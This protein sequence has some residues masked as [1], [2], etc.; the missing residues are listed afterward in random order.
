MQQVINLAGCGEVVV[1]DDRAKRAEDGLKGFEEQDGLGGRQEAA[2]P[3]HANPR[4][5]TQCLEVVCRVILAAPRVNGSV[6]QLVHALKSRNARRE[7]GVTGVRRNLVRHNAASGPQQLRD[8]P[9]ARGRICLV[10]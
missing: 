6:D 4:I 8:A 10:D 2:L 3:E 5:P 9:E 7:R 1:D